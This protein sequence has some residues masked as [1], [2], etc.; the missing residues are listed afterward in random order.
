MAQ[1]QR[2]QKPSSDR[3]AKGASQRT[4]PNGTSQDFLKALASDTRKSISSLAH[5]VKTI[6][7]YF[8]DAQEL[9]QSNQAAIPCLVDALAE[10][11][12]E[13]GLLVIL[14]STNANLVC[15]APSRGKIPW[16]Q[17]ISF[18]FQPWTYLPHKLFS[19]A[20]PNGVAHWTVEH[21][22][23]LSVAAKLGRPL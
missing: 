16:E 4:R 11:K 7:I 2:E 21:A 17:S 6:V 8:D 14:A 19:M 23:T 13:S 5:Q 22:R 3:H 1:E 18:M 10:V 20:P 15:L 12:S 9:T